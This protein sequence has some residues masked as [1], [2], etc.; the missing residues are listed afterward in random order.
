MSKKFSVKQLKSPDQVFKA[1]LTFV[2]YLRNNVK[3]YLMFSAVIVVVTLAYVLI[4]HF[5]NVRQ[6]KAMTTFYQ[7]SKGI[8]EQNSTDP[9]VNIGIIESKLKELGSSRAGVEA[10]YMLAELYYETSQWDKA[11]D[12]YGYVLKNSKGLIKELSYMG[13]AYSFEAKGDIQGA[14]DNFKHLSQIKVG[15]YKAISMLGVARCYKKLGDSIKAAS[16]YEY[17]IKMYPDTDYAKMAA[18]SKVEL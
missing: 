15:A 10:R 7:L 6:D 11:I 14:L 3:V 18:V 8:R 4:N 12:N 13:I 17:V 5:A 1:M 2:N 9:S 16:A